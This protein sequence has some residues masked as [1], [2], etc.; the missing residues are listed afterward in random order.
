MRNVTARRPHGHRS[1]AAF[2]QAQNRV[3]VKSPHPFRKAGRSTLRCA[4]AVSEG[5]PAL[6][7][8]PCQEVDHEGREHVS[9]RGLVFSFLIY[10]ADKPFPSLGLHFLLC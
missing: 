5:C 8:S 2:K 4:K 9:L 3:S 6:T 10:M 1:L 7:S